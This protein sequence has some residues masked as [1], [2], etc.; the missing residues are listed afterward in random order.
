M[1]TGGADAGVGGVVVRDMLGSDPR[2]Q[3]P[4]SPR[5]PPLPPLRLPQAHAPGLPH[6]VVLQLLRQPYR[7]RLPLSQLPP[8]LQDGHLRMRERKGVRAGVPVQHLRRQHA[9]LRGPHQRSRAD[10][11]GGERWRQQRQ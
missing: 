3:H 5:V 10:D 9:H 6:H 4:D 11:A 1:L 7:L 8:E 2:Q